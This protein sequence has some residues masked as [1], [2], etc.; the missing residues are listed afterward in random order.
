[1]KATNQS[2][3][4]QNYIILCELQ[5]FKL[6]DSTEYDPFACRKSWATINRAVKAMWNTMF[7][8]VFHVHAH[9]PDLTG[10]D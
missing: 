2:T 3:Q 7:N 5:F 10:I 1:M 9:L 6:F 8:V 4:A